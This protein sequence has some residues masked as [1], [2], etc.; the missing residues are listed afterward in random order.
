[1]KRFIQKAFL[2]NFN[3]SFV[4]VFSSHDEVESEILRLNMEVHMETLN[5]ADKVL[6]YLLESYKKNSSSSNSAFA[7]VTKNFSENE[8]SQL[9]E[10]VNKLKA[11]GFVEVMYYNSNPGSIFVKLSALRQIG[12]SAFADKG[13]NSYNQIMNIILPSKKR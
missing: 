13:Y 3:I 10:A 4:F 2:I 6:I 9:I 5:L 1:L 11:D 8:E 7:A 12:E